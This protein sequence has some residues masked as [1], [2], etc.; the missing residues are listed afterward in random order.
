[1]QMYIAT[2]QE[3]YNICS[4]YY[5]E[6]ISHRH[7]FSIFFCLQCLLYVSSFVQFCIS[8]SILN[9]LCV[10]FS[11][12]FSPLTLFY[13]YY[14]TLFVTSSSFSVYVWLCFSVSWFLSFYFESILPPIVWVLQFCMS[15]CSHEEFEDRKAASGVTHHCLSQ[16]S[17]SLSSQICTWSS[18]GKHKASYEP[19]AQGQL[20]IP[21][22]VLICLCLISLMLMLVS[23]RLLTK[24]SDFLSNLACSLLSGP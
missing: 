4:F 14:I 19:E 5:N 9:L 7:E 13:C 15:L 17:F 24:L 6:Y 20:L 18:T 11:A 10:L 16:I 22:M 3:G 21:K 8:S 1:M 12:C 2:I 23:P